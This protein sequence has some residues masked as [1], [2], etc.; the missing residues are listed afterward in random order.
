MG[1]DEDIQELYSFRDMLAKLVIANDNYA[2]IFLRIEDEITRA[3][4]CIAAKRAG[5][6]L[7]QARAIAARQRAI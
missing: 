5:N 1:Q 2:P 7:E 6:V 4:A 3:E